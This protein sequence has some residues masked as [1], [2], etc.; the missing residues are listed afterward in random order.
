MVQFA[1]SVA[2][3][4]GGLGSSVLV[5]IVM[6]IFGLCFKAGFSKSLRGGIYTGI[7][8]AG[9]S[10]I[11]DAAT[12]ALTPAITAFSENFSKDMSV[13]D[14]GWGSS[15]IAFAWPGLAFVIIGTLVVNLILILCKGTKTM[16]T[17]IWSIWHGNV[18]GGFVWI[19]TGSVG[20]GIAAAIIF[21]TI[22]S[23][24]ADATAKDYQEFNDMP[25]IAVPCTVTLLGIIAKPFNKLI[26]AIPGVR[27]IDWSP[28][29][30]RK[31]MGVFGEL[32]VMGFV[33][34]IVIGILAK[35]P[36]N[37]CLSLGIQVGVLMVFLPKTVSV[38]CEGVIPIANA[39][40]ELV[41]DKF[42]GRDLYVGVDCAALLGHP[43]VMASAVILYPL[44]VLLAV[45]LP[46]NKLLP[47]ASLA[48][49]PYWC[50]A[51]APQLKGNVFR[52]IL[53]VLL[54]TIP[55]MYLATNF[56]EIHT[57]T[58][59]ACG[60]A[61]ATPLNSSFDMGGDLIGNLIAAIFGLFK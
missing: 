56:A 7:G 27:D 41:Q 55:V 26:E 37:S 4:L 6:F 24:V 43:S 32:G 39:I 19:I 61:D 40:V 50:G 48:V 42:E 44:V 13:V 59:A 31:K 36:Y 29:N 15:G 33:I 38:L 30:I 14:V 60:L 1:A 45:L 58:M 34:G 20:L 17:D 51:C 53:F 22:G 57:A 18:L 11:I 8:L 49:I 5:A 52:I 35:F 9:L 21:L 23:F 16:W 12:A 2:G 25:G 28:E 54:W 10:V 3:V 46:G 47:I